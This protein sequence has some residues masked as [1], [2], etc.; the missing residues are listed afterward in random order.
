VAQNLFLGRQPTRFGYAKAS[1]L[2]GVGTRAMTL[3]VHVWCGLCAALAGVIA[4]ADILGADA[5]NTGP[6]LEL[7][8]I[9][10]VV[11]GGTSLFGGRLSLVLAVLGALIIQAMNEHRHAAVRLPTRIRPGGQSRGRAGDTA[12]G[13][14]ANAIAAA[15]RPRTI[16]VEGAQMNRLLPVLITTAVFIAGFVF[17]GTLS[18]WWTKIAT[19]VLLFAFIVFQQLMVGFAKRSGRTSRAIAAGVALP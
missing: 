9:L 17:D 3:A 16:A 7:D 12:V 13:G 18:N 5:N 10:A 11:I 6:W 1:E 8:A 15:C 14:T 4:V 19:G 2:A